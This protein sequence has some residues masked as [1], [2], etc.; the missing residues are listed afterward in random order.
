M[1]GNPSPIERRI[2]YVFRDKSLLTQALTHSTHAYENKRLGMP[3]NERLEFLG[4]SILGL[5]VGRALFGMD[6]RLTEGE[7]T[8]MRALVVC[9]QSLASVAREIDLGSVLLLGIGEERTGGRDKKSNLSN[10]ME[11]LFGAAFLDGGFEAAS[12]LILRLMRGILSDAKSGD[13]V[14]DFKSRLIERVQGSTPPGRIR[15]LLTKETG[16]EHNRVFTTVVEIDDAVA[17]EGTG[18][19]KKESE[20]AA[21]RS[22]LERLDRA[23]VL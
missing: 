17:G 15:F 6:E 21:A 8:A 18:R 11:A 23:M 3:D 1:P 9:E 4:D 22:A 10:A 7:M 14:R 20:Q 19:S 2:G 5:V 16:P 13:M 12:D